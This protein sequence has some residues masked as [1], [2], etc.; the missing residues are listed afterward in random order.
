[1][2]PE[3]KG[4]LD[5][6]A[7]RVPV[8][9]GSA[10]DLT[11]TLGREATVDE[12]NAA[13]KA[14][15]DGPLKGYLTYTE[16]PIVSSRHR[17]RPGVVH[18]RR[19]PD[20]GHRQ[21]GQGRRLVRQRVGLLQPPRRPDRARRLVALSAMR[22]L[23]D[24]LGARRRAAG[25]SS[26]A[27]TSTS[28]SRTAPVTDDGRIRASLP[29]LTKLLDARRPGHRRRA[30][31]PAEGRAGPAVLAAPGRR[32]AG[33]AAR[34]AG[35]VRARH[36][37]RE[38]PAAGRRARAT[39]SC[40]CWRTSG[41]TPGETSKDDAERREF[42]ARAGRAHRRRGR[43]RR[44]RRGRVRCRAP[45]ARLG[46][47]RRHAAA[48]LLRRPR[49]RRARRCCAGSPAT[50]SGPTS[51]CSA[52]SKV[53]DKLAVIES[54]LPKVDRLLVG[55]GMCFTFLAAQGHE[56]GDSLLEADQI[57]TCR[58]L[59]RRRPA[60]RSCCRPTSWSPPRSRADAD[61]RGRRRPT[62]SRP[63][64][65]AWT[66]ART[67]SRAFA[68]ALADAPHGVLERPDGRVR[69][70]AVRR[71][72]P[73][74][75]EAVAAVDGLSRRRRRRLRRGG[76]RARPRR[77]RVRPHLHRRRRLPGVP[78]GQGRCPASPSWRRPDVA[79]RPTRRA[80]HAA[81]RRQLEDEPQPPRGHR[82]GAEAGLQ[83]E[84]GAASPRSR[85]RCCRRSSTCAAC[86]RSSTA[87]G[88]CS[89]YGAQDLSPHDSGA[90]TG[91]ISGPMLAK[92]GCTLRRRRALRAARVPR[93]GRR[94]GQRQGAWP[95]YRNGLDPDPVRRRAARG[96]RG[97]RARRALHGP[98]RRRRWPASPPSR[99]RRSSSPTS[100]S[101]RSAPARSP[102]PRTRRRCAPRSAARLGRAVLAPSWPP[103]SGSSTAVRSRPPTPRELLA[104]P[105]VDGALVGGASL[106][107]RRVRRRS[108]SRAA[109]RPAG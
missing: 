55:G 9:T 104:Q 91:D 29:V 39:A 20:Q 16:D 93:R 22:T 108:A 42:A 28:R 103:A 102:R 65:R 37:R 50:P 45:Q 78:R 57:D 8:P 36:G 6:Y 82:A 97:R 68:A 101:G 10:T 5:G 88:C 96:P 73:G 2:L 87:T 23:D 75:A 70:R 49:A 12:V 13:Y 89:R 83:P 35:R 85:S 21:P 14:A 47:R 24:L 86:R 109:A 80:A 98:A 62:R 1:M 27:P 58:R 71:R 15:A 69:G 51:S 33:A 11:V 105:D 92:L 76:A 46:L 30:P 66:S 100:R 56:V 31:R 84:R 17:H 38:R 94:G 34:P 61:A 19:R 43:G 44:V 32:P 63:A 77:E 3:L 99:P 95:R 18:L 25:G 7:L 26:S 81:D 48:A 52:A 4:K 106:D 90:Y 54:L 67:R 41:S 40:C 107:A 74:V 59:A 60:T 53:S 64:G 79:R 72:H